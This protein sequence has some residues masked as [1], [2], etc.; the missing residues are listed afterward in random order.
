MKSVGSLAYLNQS[1]PEDGLYCKP[2]WR[3]NLWQLFSCLSR[4]AFFSSCQPW[5][6]ECDYS[7][8]HLKMLFTTK[9]TFI[10]HEIVISSEGDDH[11]LWSLYENL[12]MENFFLV[13]NKYQQPHIFFFLECTITS[14]RVAGMARDFYHSVLYNMYLSDLR[15]EWRSGDA[16]ESAPLL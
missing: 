13:V 9:S 1:A 14:L 11:I 7:I 6:S 3:A 12:V 10:N 4:F 2:I 16:R 5:G 15:P 8:L